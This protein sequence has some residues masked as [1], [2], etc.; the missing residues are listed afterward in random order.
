[1]HVFFKEFLL[2]I[3]FSALYFVLQHSVRTDR[4]RGLLSKK[5]TGVDRGG[6][7]VK[8]SKNVRTSVID[9]PLRDSM[10]RWRL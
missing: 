6:E 3:V 4:G 2:S 8:T 10:G 9:D 1:M 7:G 5:R